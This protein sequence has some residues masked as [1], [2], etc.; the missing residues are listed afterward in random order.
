MPEPLP[1]QTWLPWDALGGL[2]VLPGGLRR[3]PAV[4]PAPAPAAA[5]RQVQRR[6]AGRGDLA[7][8]VRRGGHRAARAVAQAGPHPRLR[9]TRAARL[10]GRPRLPEELRRGE[11]LRAERAARQLLGRGRGPGG[12]GHPADLPAARGRRPPGRAAHRPA[13]VQ[14]P[15]GAAAAQGDAA[16]GAHRGHHAVPRVAGPARRHRRGRALPE[17]GQPP[18]GPAAAAV[19][20]AQPVLPGAAGPGRGGGRAA[21]R[22]RG[23]GGASAGRPLAPGAPGR[24]LPGAQGA[25]AELPRAARARLLRQLVLRPPRRRAARAGAPGAP[26]GGGRRQRARH[27]EAGHLA[28][29]RARL[30]GR[31]RGPTR[32]PH[33]RR[34]LQRVGSPDGGAGRGEV[35]LPALL[36]SEV[37]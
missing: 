25:A 7:V 1:L 11:Y 2:S 31:R 12:R 18:R 30:Q 14:L 26:R 4:Q 17:D 23:R 8:P 3:S 19:P 10:P 5:A 13:A 22:R 28:V 34:G 27:G 35:T 37:N 6:G 32:S 15:P 21:G 20:R 24:R 9:R 36:R 29:P 16:A 33:C